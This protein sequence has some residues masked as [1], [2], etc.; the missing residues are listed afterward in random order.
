MT[1]F[2]FGGR[3]TEG[4][5]LPSRDSLKVRHNLEDQGLDGRIILKCILQKLDGVVGEWIN[6]ADDIDHWWAAVSSVMSVRLHEMQGAG[7]V[8]VV[9]IVCGRGFCSWRLLSYVDEEVH[10]AY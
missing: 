1:V 4:G 6:L 5:T 7:V 10:C 3:G 9:L 8:D 2:G